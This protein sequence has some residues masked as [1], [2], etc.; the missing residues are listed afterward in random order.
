MINR[1]L[2]LLKHTLWSAPKEVKSIT[3]KALCRAILKYAGEAWD[4]YT[5]TLCSDVELVQNKAIRLVLNLGPATTPSPRLEK[6]LKL[7]TLAKKRQ[8]ACFT[9]FHQ[10]SCFSFS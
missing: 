2:G 7:Y 1:V 5:N 8:G 9:L 10:A 3:Y 6:K 4:P